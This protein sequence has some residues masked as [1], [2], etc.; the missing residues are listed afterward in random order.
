VNYPSRAQL[1]QKATCRKCGEE[2]PLAQIVVVRLSTGVFY[3]RPRCKDCHNEFERGRRREWKRA[4]LSRWRKRNADAERSYWDNDSNR[5]RARLRAARL[6]SDPEYHCALLI[7]GRLRRRLGLRVPIAEAKELLHRFG[8]A[9]PT[10]HGLTA[11]GL[12]ECERIRS[13][14][15]R[16]KHAPSM[17]EIRMM[18]YEDS[19]IYGSAKGGGFVL[20]PKR[21]RM[22]YASASKK[23][24]QYWARKKAA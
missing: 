15:R 1:P 4:Y 5:E 11:S 22:P 7:Q 8:P 20:D 13:R 10:R 16:D 6:F 18:V 23:M 9:Y 14:T 2:K 12:R 21:Q 17:I 19:G 24:R 3:V